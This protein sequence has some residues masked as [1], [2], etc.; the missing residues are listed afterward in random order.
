MRRID[1]WTLVVPII[2]GLAILGT[3]IAEPQFLAA[4]NLQNV[5][6]QSVPLGM[7]AMAQ[8]LA[9]LTRGLDLSQGGVVVVVSVAFAFLAQAIGTE[10]AIPI[11]LL[12]GLTA[13]M[14]NGAIVAGFSVSPFVVTLGVGSILQGVALIAANGQPISTVPPNFSYLFYAQVFGI[15]VPLLVSIGVCIALWFL[16]QR[17]SLGRQIYAVGSNPRAAYLAGIPVRLT[18]L[19][20]YGLAGLLTAGG[21]VLLSSRIASGHPTAGSDA[22]L[23]AVAAA[24]IGGVS[25]FGGRGSVVGALIGAAFL[26]LLANALNLLG[27]SSFMQLVAVGLAIIIAVIA[28]KGRTRSRGEGT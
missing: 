20:T 12:V 1:P 22:A 17:V 2:A 25:L 18:V 28:D 21:S 19:W 9:I 16:L 23:Q 27:I 8:T 14:V 7:F 13:G 5:V 15:P 26:G 11:A 10:L 24:V 4:T 3:A 6:R